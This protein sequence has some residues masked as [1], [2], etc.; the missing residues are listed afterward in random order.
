MKIKRPVG[1]SASKVFW[2]GAVTGKDYWDSNNATYTTNAQIQVASLEDTDY[3]TY[4]IEGVQVKLGT[5]VLNAAD[6][7]VFS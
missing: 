6:L 2:T 4:T 3:G 5:H 7:K 1:S